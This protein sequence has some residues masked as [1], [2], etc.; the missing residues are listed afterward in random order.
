MFTSAAPV[1]D[2]SLAGT[3]IAGEQCSARAL[4]TVR[5]YGRAAKKKFNLIHHQIIERSHYPQRAHP[6]CRGQRSTEKASSSICDVPS[7]LDFS[8]PL[9][10]PSICSHQ[11]AQVP[12]FTGSRR[13]GLLYG[14]H[15]LNDRAHIL[16]ASSPAFFKGTSTQREA[17]LAHPKMVRS[18]KLLRLA[19]RPG[20]LRQEHISN[21]RMIFPQ[22][23]SKA[24]TVLGIETSADDT[25]VVK[26]VFDESPSGEC[27][28]QLLQETRVT[29]PNR[30]HRGIHP[31]EAVAHHT[32]YLSPLVKGLIGNTNKPDLICVTR[33]PGMGGCLS[34]GVTT[35]KA[36]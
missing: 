32:K 20:C 19:L 14:L 4:C 17:N 34:V 22:R 31:V 28:A 11:R 36:L 33:G 24:T 9:P 35:A 16:C 13:Y 23:R 18:Q 12:K 25:C 5:S 30:V 10:Q 29:C 15:V 2:P 27:R 3:G 8:Q 7:C 26:C 6:S 1:G 21:R